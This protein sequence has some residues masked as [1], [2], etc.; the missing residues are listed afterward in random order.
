VSFNLK[1]VVFQRFH[2]WYCHTVDPGARTAA[3]TR[4]PLL[5]AAVGKAASHAGQTTLYVTPMHGKADTLRPLIADTRAALEYIGAG[6][7]QF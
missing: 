6:A 5:L 1:S 2:I 4:R 7:E 3:F